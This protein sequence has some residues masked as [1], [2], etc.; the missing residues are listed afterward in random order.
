VP[1]ALGAESI[2]GLFGHP[3]MLLPLNSMSRLLVVIRVLAI[4]VSQYSRVFAR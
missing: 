2:V 3:V 4:C 1:A